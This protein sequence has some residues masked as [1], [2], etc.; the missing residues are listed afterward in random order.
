M[1]ILFLEQFSDPGGGQR[2]MLDLLP[3]VRER[4]WQAL[5]A[6]PGSGALFDL[7]R[8]EG[9]ETA[10][11]ELGPYT[12]GRKTPADVLRYMR[13]TRRLGQWIGAQDCDVIYA[14]GPRPLV[15][16]T[17][18]ARG[19]PV[20]FHAQS[21]LIKGYAA[22]LVRWAIR[23]ANATVIADSRHI[24]RPIELAASSRLH[25]VYNGVPEIP[26]RSHEFGRGG[27]WRIG[28]IG[29][30]APEKGQLDLLRAAPSMLR[31]LPEA[32]FVIAGAPLFSPPAYLEAVRELTRDLPVDLLGWR[33]DVA[34]VL[35][36]LDLLVVPSDHLEAT[37]RVIMEAYSAGV[38]VIAYAN[39]GI[40]EVVEDGVTGF[41]VPECSPDALAAKVL[42]VVHSDLSAIAKRA[43]AAWERDFNV[44]RYR[45]EMLDII[46]RAATR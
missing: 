13:D 30:V 9:A 39:G 43:R 38:P 7:A 34:A 14:S 16:A 12:S 27:A 6:A 32:R 40:P 1:K 23:R 24:A 37:T 21:L 42:Q 17:L 3:G 4:D 22:R 29:R 41:L 28:L 19:R 11:I 26:F 33:D 20:I 8:R 5:V 45:T 35:A 46:A 31:E 15:A 44:E 18:G 25:I 36:D 2:C 10:A